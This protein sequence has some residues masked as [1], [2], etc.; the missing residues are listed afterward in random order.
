MGASQAKE[1]ARGGVKEVPMNKDALETLLRE[2]KWLDSMAAEDTTG[3]NWGTA[4]LEREWVKR[5]RLGPGMVVYEALNAVREDGEE[6]EVDDGGRFEQSVGAGAGAGINTTS[7]SQELGSGS[8]QGA[9]FSAPINSTT[10]STTTTIVEPEDRI[11]EPVV[12]ANAK[13]DSP[14]SQLTE[15]EIRAEQ[16]KQNLTAAAMPTSRVSRLLH[17]GGNFDLGGNT[18]RGILEDCEA[19]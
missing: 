4:D 10:T 1:V 13:V 15:E 8:G 16:V 6:V 3:L 12:D 18:V 11:V 17:Y 9:S 7:V 2:S 19:E 5:E 14:S